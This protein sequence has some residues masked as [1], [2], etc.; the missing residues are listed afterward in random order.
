M[1]YSLINVYKETDGVVSGTWIQ[2]HTGTLDTAT[3][4]ARA[5]EKANSGRITVAVVEELNYS[6]PNYCY[7]T[8][9]LRLDGKGG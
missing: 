9:L 5:T 3:A 6:A 2:N 1:K 4:V 8:G 7:R